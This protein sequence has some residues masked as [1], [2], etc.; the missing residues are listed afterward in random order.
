MSSA[1]PPA[2]TLLGFRLSRQDFQQQIVRARTPRATA[3]KGDTV[4][5]Q[6]KQA[7]VIRGYNDD[8]TA[9]IR[10]AAGGREEVL[11]ASYMIGKDMRLTSKSSVR[12]PEDTL[13]Y[14]EKAT[15]RPIGLILVPEDAIVEYL[16]KHDYMR[17]WKRLKLSPTSPQASSMDILAQAQSMFHLLSL[18]KDPHWAAYVAQR[19]DAEWTF[20]KNATRSVLEHTKLTAAEQAAVSD[21]VLPQGLESCDDGSDG[22]YWNDATVFTRIFSPTRP[23]MSDVYL[24]YPAPCNLKIIYR[25]HSPAP[26]ADE[27]LKIFHI[28]SL[29]KPEAGHDDWRLLFNVGFER[30]PCK[31]K[32]GYRNTERRKWGMKK[33]EAKQVRD[34]LFGPLGDK[35][36]ILEAV[37]FVLTTVAPHE[38][39]H[40]GWR[41]VQTG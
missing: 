25:I 17:Q 18:S 7:I 2:R 20:I 15:D 9:A 3:A 21:G 39:S 30:V 14:S 11:K 37:L 23:A 1:S 26:S 34:V 41:E 6:K 22:V 31:G 28:R 13:M 8:A 38:G 35:V 4:S 16:S 19:Q 10:T 32:R 12:N 40:G 5:S 24:H 33:T 29:K 27:R 36:S